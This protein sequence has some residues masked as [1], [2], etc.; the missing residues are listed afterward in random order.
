MEGAPASRMDKV[1]MHIP[2]AP[3]C[4]LACPFGGLPLRQPQSHQ[5]C[6]REDKANIC[7]ALRGTQ[8]IN[9]LWFCSSLGQYLVGGPS[10]LEEAAEA[11]PSVRLQRF[12]I[13]TLIRSVVL[14]GSYQDSMSSEFTDALIRAIKAQVSLA[15]LQAFMDSLAMHADELLTLDLSYLEGLLKFLPFVIELKDT[16]KQSS[17]VCC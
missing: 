11:E 1:C 17:I 6:T 10:I 16:G 4:T 3:A 9:G 2:L 14:V 8:R 5:A 7:Y 13:Q 12:I 15:S